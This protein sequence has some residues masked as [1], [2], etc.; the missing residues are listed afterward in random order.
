VVIFVAF[1]IIPH[2][3]TSVSPL[4]D[5]GQ[6]AL[7]DQAAYAKPIAF[8][9]SHPAIVATAQK[10]Q[11][12][13]LIEQQFAPEFAVLQKNPALFTK[14]ATYSDP[15]KIPPR[16]LSQAIA[17][18]GG[19]AKGLGILTTI[20]A[21]QKA[22]QSVAAVAPQLQPLAP[23]AA[24]LTALSKVPPSVLSFL[25]AHGPAVRKAQ[26]EAPG[27]WKHWYWVCFGGII[28]FLLC[29]PLL[30]GRW[31]PADARRDEEEHEAITQA[32]LAKLTKLNV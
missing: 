1:L 24:Q 17:T 30:H 3:I 31:R 12:Q 5:Y 20:S 11:A 6:T 2:V 21:N 9:L 28:F 10:Y 27:Q 13:L 18:A 15:A 16:L 23:Y 7:A 32:E 22:I 25:Q 4:V 26:A 8:A 14:L 19:G 29:I